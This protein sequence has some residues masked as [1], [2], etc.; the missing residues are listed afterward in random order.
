MLD[1]LDG[2]DLPTVNLRHLV[3]P[4]RLPSPQLVLRV[5]RESLLTAGSRLLTARVVATLAPLGQNA[6]AVASD[7]I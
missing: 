6:R 1:S 4:W 2:T 3:R 5:G 7:T